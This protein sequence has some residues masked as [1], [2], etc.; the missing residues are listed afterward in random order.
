MK[1]I[2][3]TCVCVLLMN[4]ISSAQSFVQAND[5]TGFTYDCDNQAGAE[6]AWSFY[7]PACVGA[8]NGGGG[9]DE[10]PTDELNIGWGQS[11]NGQMYLILTLT[12]ALN[13]SSSANQKLKVTLRSLNGTTSAAMPVNYTLRMEDASNAALLTPIPLAV[14]GTNQVFDL[15]LSGSIASGQNLSAVKKIIFH[16]D[17]CPSGTVYTAPGNPAR[18]VL[19]N[20][21]AGSLL[22]SNLLDANGIVSNANLFPNPSNGITQISAELPSSS[23]VKITLMD[24]YGQSV[25]TIAEGNYTAINESFDVSD[26][27]KGIYFVH[28]TINGKVAKVQRLVVK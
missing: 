3:F 19:S 10:A 20:F 1:N 7:G 28:Y 17:G 21:S 27:A 5:N 6:F 26:I 13:L 18:L 22:V 9:T 14:T 24:V 12:N 23:D 8:D 4:Q 11:S 25:K 2:I 16:Y 15:N